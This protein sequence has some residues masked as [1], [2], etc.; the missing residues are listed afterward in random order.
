MITNPV[1]GEQTKVE[2]ENTKLKGAFNSL[3]LPPSPFFLAAG[4]LSCTLITKLGDFLIAR[5]LLILPVVIEDFEV[6]K[7]APGFLK[8]SNILWAFN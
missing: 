7:S 8:S 3:Y 1:G 5:L 6:R 2:R 4:V